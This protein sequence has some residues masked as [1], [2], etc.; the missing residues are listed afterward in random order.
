MYHTCNQYD[1]YTRA[2]GDTTQQSNIMIWYDWYRGHDVDVWTLGGAEEE[3]IGG[4]AGRFTRKFVKE[5]GAVRSKIDAMDAAVAYAT[6]N[7]MPEAVMDDLYSIL[8]GIRCKII[9]Y[10]LVIS[11]IMSYIILLK[12]SRKNA[13]PQ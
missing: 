4:M 7:M 12:K 3:V 10:S 6:N 1:G 5:K 9:S 13:A 2:E 8:G 11:R